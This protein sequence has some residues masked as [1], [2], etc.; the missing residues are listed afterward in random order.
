MPNIA[1]VLKEEVARVAR[2]E[3]R[4]ETQRLKKASTV[5]RSAIAALKRRVAALEKQL[6]RV[7]KKGVKALAA[8]PAADEGGP[9]MRFSAQGVQALRKRLGL[10][11]PQLAALLAVSAQTIYNWEAN[12]ARP[13]V[14]Q[15]AAMASLRSLGKRGAAAK[16]VEV[17]GKPKVKRPR[18]ARAKAAA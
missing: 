4:G 5:Y 8:A 12:K 14:R 1:S 2:K 6:A 7:E 16:L 11:A 15:L 13:R 17:E 9:R 18:K 3:L 10:S